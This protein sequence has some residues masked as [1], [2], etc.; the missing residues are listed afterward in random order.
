MKDFDEKLANLR[1]FPANSSGKPGNG[2]TTA[3]KW[4]TGDAAAKPKAKWL[5]GAYSSVGGCENRRLGK[6]LV[7]VGDA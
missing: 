5:P 2:T 7:A 1:W 4:T 6:I 3:S